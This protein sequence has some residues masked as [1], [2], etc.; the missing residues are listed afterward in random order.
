MQ[1]CQRMAGVDPVPA[2]IAERAN[3]V[4]AVA[5]R[6]IMVVDV[7]GELKGLKGRSSVA[8]DQAPS[9]WRRGRLIS[10]VIHLRRV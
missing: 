9:A 8:A 7:G 6:A 2:A 10:H 1:G 4:E 3:S 5:I